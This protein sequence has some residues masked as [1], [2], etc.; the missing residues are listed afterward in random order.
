MLIPTLVFAFALC[1]SPLL[2]LWWSLTTFR[3]DELDGGRVRLTL[4]ADFKTMEVYKRLLA[5]RLHGLAREK[6]TSIQYNDFCNEFPLQL[7][8][9]N[10][11]YDAA[12]AKTMKK[13]R[14]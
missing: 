7:F 12:Y 1:G 10:G 3:K 4:N 6:L 9:A 14:L 2:L 5:E 11:N 13:V 8:K